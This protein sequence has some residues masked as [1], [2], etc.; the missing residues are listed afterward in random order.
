MS[1]QTTT[2]T[3]IPAALHYKW[4]GLGWEKGKEPYQWCIFHVQDVR[5]DDMVTRYRDGVPTE[6]HMSHPN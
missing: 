5:C 4:A 6:Q 2:T 3:T 1:G